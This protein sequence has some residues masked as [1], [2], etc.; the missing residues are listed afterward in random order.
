MQTVKIPENLEDVSSLML[1]QLCKRNDWKHSDL[2]RMLGVSR[3][4]AT[5]LVNGKLT[6][7]LIQLWT[8]LD[9]DGW[10]D[11]L[12]AMDSFAAQL[13]DDPENEDGIPNLDS[14]E[15]LARHQG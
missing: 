14:P 2:A 5:R 3:S 7:N 11:L 13:N 4:T 12:D 8:L 10:D 15:E 6:P 9:R 1:D